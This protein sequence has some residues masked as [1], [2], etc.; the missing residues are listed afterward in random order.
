MKYQ[1]IDGMVWCDEIEN[2]VYFDEWIEF[3]LSELQAKIAYKNYLTF[4]VNGGFA[5]LN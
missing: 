1:I 5:D 3:E 4:N 2:W